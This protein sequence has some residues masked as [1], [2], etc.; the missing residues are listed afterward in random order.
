MATK[1]FIKSIDG[2]AGGTIFWYPEEQIF[3]TEEDLSGFSE[4]DDVTFVVSDGPLATSV[5]AA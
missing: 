1:G 5:T 4:G 3:D 2:S